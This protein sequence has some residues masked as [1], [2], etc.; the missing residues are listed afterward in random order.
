LRVGVAGNEM[1]GAT[2]AEE[3]VAL[4]ANHSVVLADVAKTPNALLDWLANGVDGNGNT[5]Q[6]AAP[7]EENAQ[8]RRPLPRL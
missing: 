4:L 7:R 6:H 8:R 2:L 5:G 3:S 1:I